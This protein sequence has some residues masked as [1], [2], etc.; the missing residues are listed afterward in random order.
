MSATPSRRTSPPGGS[1]S[2]RK[3]CHPWS[4]IPLPFFLVS[5]GDVNATYD[6]DH[7]QGINFAD[8]ILT[9]WNTLSIL[10]SMKFS[11]F[12]N[13]QDHAEELIMS[14]N[15]RFFVR[16]GSACSNLCSFSCLLCFSGNHTKNNI[17]VNWTSFRKN[18]VRFQKLYVFLPP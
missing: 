4:A 3:T 5:S 14:A 18:R 1:M 8:M 11:I 9:S 10:K 12:L 13:P 6:V 7:M 17:K 15:N 2:S 16:G